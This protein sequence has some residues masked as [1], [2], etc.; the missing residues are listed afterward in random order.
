MDPSRPLQQELSPP[1]LSSEGE[2]SGN[3]S[4]T[5]GQHLPGQQIG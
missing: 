2:R 5:T 3:V 1:R 4:S